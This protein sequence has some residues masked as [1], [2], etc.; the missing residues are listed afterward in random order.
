MAEDKDGKQ[1]PAGGGR[2]GWWKPMAFA[3]VGAI[4]G[5]AGVVLLLPFHAANKPSAPALPELEQVELPDLWEFTFNPRVERGHRVAQISFYIVYRQDKKHEAEVTQSLRTNWN[6]AYSRCMEVL[7]NT[8]LA[9][10]TSFDGKQKL[11]ARLRDELTA[12]LFPGG[13]AS[14]DDVLWKKFNVQ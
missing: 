14:V 11:R 9:T 7:T 3:A 5:G 6:R 10:L 8:P 4:A 13:I 12:A 1:P 2:K